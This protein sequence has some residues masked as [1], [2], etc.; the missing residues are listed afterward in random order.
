VRNRDEQ[1]KKADTFVEK[2]NAALPDGHPAK[3]SAKPTL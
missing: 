2:L 3:K 1:R